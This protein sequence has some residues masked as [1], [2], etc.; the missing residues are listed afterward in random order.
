M[1]KTAIGDVYVE[2]GTEDIS[3][4]LESVKIT[5]GRSAVDVTAVGDAW[6]DYVT[7]GIARWAVTLGIY[8]DYASSDAGCNLYQLVK[9]MVTTELTGTTFV[10]RPTSAAAGRLNPQIAGTVVM[11]GD[12]DFLTAAA[13]TANKYSVTLKGMTTPTFTDTSS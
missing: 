5:L 13:N 6:A 3:N 12:F 4:R 11:D 2:L 8:Q 1:A 10:C 9:T 7:G